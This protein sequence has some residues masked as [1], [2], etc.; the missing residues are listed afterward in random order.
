MPG[1]RSRSL[2]AMVVAALLACGGGGGG[3][4]GG[5]TNPPPPGPAPSPPSASATVTLGAASFTPSSVSIT[6]NGTV[7]WNNTSGLDHNVTFN[8]AAGAPS[9]IATH[10]SGSNQRSFSAA[11]SFAYGCTLHAGMNGTVT[12]Q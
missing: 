11:G 1:I 3:G 9:N 6:L 7:T 12:V 8:A 10:N 4:G 5:I 2:G